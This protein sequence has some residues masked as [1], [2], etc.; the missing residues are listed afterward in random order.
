MSK[1]AF[2]KTPPRW[3]FL[4]SMVVAVAIEAAA[5]AAASLRKADY[6]PTENGASEEQAFQGV[7]IEEPPEPAQAPPEDPP[8]APLP[9][10][11]EATDFVLTEP[12]PPPKVSRVVGPVTRVKTGLSRSSRV[13]SGP[14]TF[15]IGQA[16]MTFSPRPSYPFEARRAKQTGSGKFLLRF[17][18][19]GNVTEVETVQSTG[20][21]FL[22]QAAL[23]TL[24]QWRCRPGIYESVYVPIT[25]TLQGVQ[26]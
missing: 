23:R 25:F 10:P 2:Y 7:I 21:A 4:V 6:I 20:S 1:P 5:V 24:R 17:H 18:A 11:D 12:T 26:L 22:D 13:K 19:G 15:V 8:I 14:A 3:H 9:P 16:R